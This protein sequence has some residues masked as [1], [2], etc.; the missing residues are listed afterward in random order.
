MVC[1][2]I[3]P[4]P[5]SCGGAAEITAEYDRRILA[6]VNDAVGISPVVSSAAYNAASDSQGSNFIAIPLWRNLHTSDPLTTGIQ[7]MNIG[8]ASARATISF[9][10]SNGDVVK[11]DDPTDWE[12]DI[13]PMSAHTWY[14]TSLGG[15]PIGMYGSAAIT[16]TGEPLLVIVNDASVA[17]VRDSA[18]YSGLIEQDGSL[19]LS[20]PRL[21]VFEP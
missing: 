19:G 17:N 2:C 14:P 8:E 18:I 5:R 7:A 11:L 3:E 10:D 13:P 21:D 1:L 4:T 6:I 20:L 15:M 16:T 12:V 9:F